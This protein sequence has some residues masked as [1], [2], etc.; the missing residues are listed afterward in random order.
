MANSTEGEWMESACPSCGVVAWRQTYDIGSGP[1]LSCASC[2]WCWGAEGQELQEINWRRI[3]QV[4]WAKRHEPDDRYREYPSHPL[5]GV[6]RMILHAARKSLLEAADW[7]S[8][9]PDEAIPLADSVVVELLPW[10]QVE[11]A[12]QAPE[13]TDGVDDT[14]VR[15]P[16]AVGVPTSGAPGPVGLAGGPED[17]VRPESVDGVA[18]QGNHAG[19]TTE[20]NE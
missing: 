17:A 7:G 8:V 5:H 14:E 1:E 20:V 6:P 18:L 10:L 15:S 2:E 16:E 11:L 19:E 3:D 13:P 12:T 9:D 4:E